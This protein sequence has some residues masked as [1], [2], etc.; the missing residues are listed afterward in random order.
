MKKVLV[1]SLAFPPVAVVGVYRVSKFCKYLPEMGFKPYVL[2]ER[3]R[4][5]VEQD[6]ATLK[7]IGDDVEIVRTLNLQPFYWW[8]NRSKTAAPRNLPKLAKSVPKSN[9]TLVPEK[10]VRL[11]P[12][13]IAR[14]ALRLLRQALTVPDARLPWIP[15][16]FIPGLRL[17]YREKIDVIFSS[18]PSPTNHVMAHLLSRFSG[19]PHIVDYR[20]LWTV[21]GSYFS[22][23][24]PR[25]M[26]RWNTFWE[27]RVLK[28]CRGVVVTTNTFRENLVAGFDDININDKITV[29]YNG[30]DEADYRDAD[31][32]VRKNDRFTVSYFG[33]LY[34]FRN[35]SQFIKALAKWID[36][37]PA[38][39]NRVKVD[40]WGSCDEGYMLDMSKHHLDKVIAFNSR[41]PQREAMRKML[42]T[43]LLL[44]IQ[45]TDPRANDAIPTKLFEYLATGKPI[46]AFF[47]EGEAAD[48]LLEHGNHLVISR[49]DI[50]SIVAYLQRHFSL[51]ENAPNSREVGVEIAPSFNRRYQTKQL[52]EFL[53]SVLRH[54]K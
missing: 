38:V 31:T 22:R 43:D 42:E 27:R 51:W 9:N 34:G 33:N 4:K 40:F 48:I 8:D 5:N 19:R 24:L 3:I 17:I 15:Q 26:R 2:T 54:R 49:P 12:R 44:L 20:D 32:T 25:L 23:N 36:L 35:P 1:I 50:D 14:R 16:A 53:N 52:A 10:S 11:S 6:W 46:L 21:S 7:D 30:V 45:G 47:P 37:N 41:I 39:K 29:I 13:R 28:H 18:S